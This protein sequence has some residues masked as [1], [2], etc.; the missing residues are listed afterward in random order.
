MGSFF[1]KIYFAWNLIKLKK[2]SREFTIYLVIGII[3][4]VIS[5]IIYLLFLM[6]SVNITVSAATG[7]I[8]GVLNTYTLGRMFI[9][10]RRIDHSNKRL[11]LFVV[12]YVLMILLTSHSIELITNL[13]LIHHYAVWLVCNA[14][15][16]C[17]NFL[18]L[19]YVALRN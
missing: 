12:Y 6:A 2:I 3:S 17:C 16:A 19:S 13:G 4:N 1:R 14:I 10:E 15:A 18:F 5:F 8:A 7:M 9:K 11:T